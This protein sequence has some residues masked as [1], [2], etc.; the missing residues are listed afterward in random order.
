MKTVNETPLYK[1]FKVGRISNRKKILARNLKQQEAQQM[2][3]S[4]KD[5]SLSMVCYT[6]Q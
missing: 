6:R 5:S 4:F 1:V 3:K 2:V